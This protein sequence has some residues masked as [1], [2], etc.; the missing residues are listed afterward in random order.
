[1]RKIKYEKTDFDFYDNFFGGIE[2]W[3]YKDIGF[4]V[5]RP[6]INHDVDP[7]T[8]FA[9]DSIMVVR[10]KVNLYSEEGS[11]SE[12]LVEMGEG[13]KVQI[14]EIGKSEIIDGVKSNWLKVKIQKGSRTPEGHLIKSGV[15]GWCFGGS[16]E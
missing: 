11:L 12:R 10:E 5:V 7:K 9:L 14:L 8:S 16:L 13:A 4:R 1:M 6:Y 2:P 15:V 3:E